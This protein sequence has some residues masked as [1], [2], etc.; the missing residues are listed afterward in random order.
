MQNV[1]SI[2]I[3]SGL[4][5][6]GVSGWTIAAELPGESGVLE[7]C[8]AYSEAGMRECLAKKVTESSTALKRAEDQTFVALSKWDEDAKYV[9]SA[10]EKLRGSSK[11]FAQYREAQCAFTLSLGGGAIG[12]A[13]EI[14]RLACIAGLNAGRA[15]QLNANAVSLTSK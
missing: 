10:Q 6:A 7:Q 8:G 13:L 9:V 3:V 14:R 15:Q 12:N 5:L 1:F 2:L 11:A 4:V